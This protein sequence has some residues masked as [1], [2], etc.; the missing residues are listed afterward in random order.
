MARAATAAGISRQ[1][2]SK[3]WNRYRREGVPGLVDRR[4]R[5]QFQARALDGDMVDAV[6]AA[7]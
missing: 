7:T 6:L 4:S 1:T 2:A 5:V 3:W